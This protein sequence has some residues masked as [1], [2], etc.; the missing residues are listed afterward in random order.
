MKLNLD[1][2]RTEIDDYL[3]NSGFVVFY[4]F[5][6]SDE[7]RVV[8][9]DTEH[10]PDY[11]QFLDVARQ[12]DVKLIVLHQRAF[13]AAII[14]RALEEMESSEVEFDDRRTLE[15]R[16]RELA[17]YDGF[18]CAVELSYEYQDT[19]YV[20]DLH[21]EWFEELGDLLAQ[22]DLGFDIDEDEDEQDESYGGYYSRN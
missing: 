11:K 4:G 21:A 22:L 2:V 10:H 17:K 8:D 1:T 5:A 12:L 16:L 13:D 20:F 19:M 3:K 9:W 18:T 6:R 15:S 7:A 14:D